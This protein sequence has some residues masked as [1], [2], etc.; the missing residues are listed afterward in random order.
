MSQE[1]FN[2]VLSKKAQRKYCD[3][4]DFPYFAPHDGYCYRCHKNI[5]AEGGFSVEAAS[6]KL[7]T[8]CPFCRASYCD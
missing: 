5:Y 4:N 7:I 2:V 1:V 3:E 8:V 6:N